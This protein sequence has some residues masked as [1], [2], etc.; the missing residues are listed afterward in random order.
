MKFSIVIPT[1]NEE[2]DIALTIESILLLDYHNTEIIIVDDSI[3]NTPKILNNYD[4]FIKV[5]RPDR[6]EG[7]CGARNIGILAATGDVV[8]ILNADVRL[9]HDFL[10]KILVHYQNGFDYVLVK[11]QVSNI[12]RLFARYVASVACAEE[13]GDPSWMEW[14]EGF[15]CRR[16]IAIK[17]GLFPV[18][19]AVPI[20]AGEDGYFGTG[21]KN[22]GAKKM[23]DFSIVVPHV[24]PS[25][26][27]EYW[28][29]RKGRGKGSPQIRRFLQKWS[30]GQ[31]TT[32][33]ALRIFK[34][35]LLIVTLIP[36][37]FKLV[38]YSKYSSRGI[39][40]I[41]LFGYAW[42]LEQMAFHVGEW[43]SILEIIKAEKIR[44]K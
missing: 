35:I 23:I 22:I 33:A 20:C 14:T 6:R 42:A 43:K 36:L 2:Q 15:S 26:L 10:K 34:N 3:D 18:G 9:P 25:K 17:A 38:K 19:F 29:I 4:K 27:D 8:V 37:L 7:R 32:R 13:S 16:N 12:D 39:L 5:I 21:L 44:T 28:E 11:S 41:P 31:I 40:D 24:A 1:Y 30:L